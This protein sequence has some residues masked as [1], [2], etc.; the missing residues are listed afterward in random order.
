MEFFIC[1][2]CSCLFQ[3]IYPIIAVNICQTSCCCCSIDGFCGTSGRYVIRMNDNRNGCDRNGWQKEDMK[4]TWGGR[5][6]TMGIN[7]SKYLILQCLYIKYWSYTR[8]EPKTKP[9]SIRFELWI[10][11]VIYN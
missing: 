3:T 10:L 11:I 6:E 7:I 5:N 4:A 9:F 8:K 2:A 1:V